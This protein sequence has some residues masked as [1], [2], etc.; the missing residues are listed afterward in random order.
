MGSG[1]IGDI[2]L[3]R[4]FCWSFLN[5]LLARVNQ[6]KNNANLDIPTT[7]ANREHCRH[8]PTA[9]PSFRGSEPA[10]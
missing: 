6:V 5:E 1:P 8:H 3:K 2:G 9:C 7:D 4:Q 10:R